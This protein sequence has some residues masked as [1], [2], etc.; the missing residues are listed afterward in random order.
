MT[1]TALPDIDRH[2]AADRPVYAGLGE[3][4]RTDYFLVSQ[5]LTEQERDYLRRTREFV[6]A[7]V[8]PVINGYWEKAEL[9]LELFCRT[10]ELGLVG[11]GIVGYG[12]PEMSITAAGLVAMESRDAPHV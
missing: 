3:S 5:E 7:E 10:G 11:D 12:C 2:P 4:L 6:H 1:D 9:P 8:L